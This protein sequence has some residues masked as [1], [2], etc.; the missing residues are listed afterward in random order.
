MSFNILTYLIIDTYI[1]AIKYSHYT[2][3]Y[4]ARII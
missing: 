1:Y 2:H 3:A 4:L